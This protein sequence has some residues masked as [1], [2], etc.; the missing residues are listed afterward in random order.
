M[1]RCKSCKGSGVVWH[2]FTVMCST[3]HYDSRD[4][5][6]PDPISNKCPVCDGRGQVRDNF[7]EFSMEGDIV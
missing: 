3:A 2:E 1:I 5:R 6:K 7:Y 4:F